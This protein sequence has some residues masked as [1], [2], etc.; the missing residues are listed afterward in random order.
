MRGDSP[1]G[2]E[3]LSCTYYETTVETSLSRLVD[4]PISVVLDLERRCIYIHIPWL[5]VP[6]LSGL[7]PP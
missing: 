5:T 2:N 3:L 1:M 6:S 4:H 7:H